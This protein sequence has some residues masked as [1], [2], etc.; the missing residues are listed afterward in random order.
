MAVMFGL[1]VSLSERAIKWAAYLDRLN[2][3][4]GLLTEGAS[5]EICPLVPGFLSLINHDHFFYELNLVI[6]TVILLILVI[7]VGVLC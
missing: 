6:F 7:L 1:L 2:V 4:I 5:Y 3:F